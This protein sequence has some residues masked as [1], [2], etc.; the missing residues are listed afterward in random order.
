MQGGNRVGLLCLGR[1]SGFFPESP[2]DVI[3]MQLLTTGTVS[4]LETEQ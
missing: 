2:R 3:C 4:H 1:N